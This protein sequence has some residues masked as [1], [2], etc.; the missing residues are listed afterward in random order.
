MRVNFGE[1]L[2]LSGVKAI[3]DI[4]DRF[5][6]RLK[7]IKLIVIQDDDLGLFIPIKI[8]IEDSH[9]EG[10]KLRLFLKTVEERQEKG[11]HQVRDTHA[12]LCQGN[13]G[14]ECRKDRK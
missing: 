3:E 5:A 7:S 6:S 10:H 12:V 2:C 9:Q 4:K 8:I 13:P 11:V 1:C 14:G